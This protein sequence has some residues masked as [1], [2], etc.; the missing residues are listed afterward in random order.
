MEVLRIKPQWRKAEARTEKRQNSVTSFQ[1]LIK[2]QLD[3]DVSLDLSVKE[4][5]CLSHFELEFVSFAT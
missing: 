3:L 4:A 1:I 2:Q 5:K